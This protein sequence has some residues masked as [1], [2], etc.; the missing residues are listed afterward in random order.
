ME[1]H[2][3]RIHVELSWGYSVKVPSTSAAEPSLLMPPPTT[4]IGAFAKG[5]SYVLG[6]RVE[7]LVDSGRLASYAVKASSF[8]ASAHAGFKSRQALTSWSDLTRSYAVPY[9]QTQ[10]RTP[11]DKAMWFGVHALGKV[12]APSMKVSL[13]YVVNASKAKAVL[14]SEWRGLLMKSSFCL[15]SLGSKE[16]MVSVDDAD[17]SPLR[18][19]SGNVVETLYYA[20]L[21]AVEAAPAGRAVLEFW[22]PRSME[23][24]LSSAKAGVSMVAYVTPL[25]VESMIPAVLRLRLSRLGVALTVD[26]DPST[27]VVLLKRW[28]E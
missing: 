23:A 11:K 10:Y 24:W 20:P 14:G 21:E 7:C 18:E 27:T 22:D 12:Y 2:L 25:D 17:L 15:S 8:I 28:L 5:L 19:V 13:A 26:S 4:L 1:L 3:L 6:D 9:L 16:G